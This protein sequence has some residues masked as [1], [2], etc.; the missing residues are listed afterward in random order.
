[1]ALKINRYRIFCNP[2]PLLRG[3]GIMVL[4]STVIRFPASRPLSPW[5]R[6]R[7]RVKP[8]I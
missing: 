4:K 8:Q 1:M 2:S 7:E 5:E 6:A 3:E